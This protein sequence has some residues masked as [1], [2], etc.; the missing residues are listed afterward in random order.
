MKSS[1]FKTSVQVKYSYL[2]RS[3]D[4]PTCNGAFPHLPVLQPVIKEPI[5]QESSTAC[6]ALGD[7]AIPETCPYGEASDFAEITPSYPMKPEWLNFLY[8]LRGGY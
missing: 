8:F 1:T 4:C 3:K 5:I 7:T 6:H 2:G